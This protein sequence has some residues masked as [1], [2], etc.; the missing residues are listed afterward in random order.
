MCKECLQYVLNQEFQ[1]EKKERKG[2]TGNG[3]YLYLNI[4]WELIIMAPL[5]YFTSEYEKLWHCANFS[6]CWT[7]F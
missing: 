6:S 2:N 1:A 7:L 5:L 4:I 3:S